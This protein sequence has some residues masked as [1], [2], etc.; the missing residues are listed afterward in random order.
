MNIA[1]FSVRLARHTVN[2]L[3]EPLKALVRY[4]DLFWLLLRRDLAERTSGTVFGFVWL[5]LQPAL[6][7]LAYWF[8]L[9]LVLQVR[10]PGRVGFVEYFLLAMLPWLMISEALGRG[11]GVLAELG[12]LYQRMTFPVVLLPLLPLALSGLIFGT[13]YIGLVA[14]VAGVAKVVY[15]PLIIL[16]LVIWLLPFIYLL[17]VLGLFVRDVRQ[18]VP[19]LLTLVMFLTPILYAAQ[20]LPPWLQRVMVFNPVADLMAVIHHLTLDLPI[21]SVEGVSPWMVWTFPWLVWLVLLGPAWVIFRRTEPHMRE[22]L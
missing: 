13:V 10:F 7:M 22:A 14:I 6:Q 19:F 20:M 15:A 11:T 4:R 17:S 18:L 2:G 3:A 1:R 9:G 8:L 16:A 12:S 21:T 5:L